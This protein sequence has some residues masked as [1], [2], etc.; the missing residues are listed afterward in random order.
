MGHGHPGLHPPE[1]Y[2]STRLHGKIGFQNKEGQFAVAPEIRFHPN[3]IQDI[4][5]TMIISPHLNMVQPTRAG[6]A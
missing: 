6:M 3:I 2:L 5:G 4:E 1:Q